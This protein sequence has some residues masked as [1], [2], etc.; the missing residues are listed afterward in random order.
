MYGLVKTELFLYLELYFSDEV[1][2]YYYD[3]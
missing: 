3:I 2:D 1:D